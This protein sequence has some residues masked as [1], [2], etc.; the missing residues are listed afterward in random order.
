MIPKPK[1]SSAAE[2]II[3]FAIDHASWG[4]LVDQVADGFRQAILAGHYAPGDRLPPMRTIAKELGVSI[5][6]PTQALARLERERLVVGRP[7]IGCEVLDGRQPGWRGHLLIVSPGGDYG[8]SSGMLKSTVCGELLRSG[9]LVTTVPIPRNEHHQYDC[10]LLN[11]A[12]KQR[13]DV[14]LLLSFEAR[15]GRLIGKTGIPL[16]MQASPGHKLPQG[17]A[18]T[19]VHDCQDALNGFAAFCSGNGVRNVVVVDK[20]ADE[21]VALRKVLVEHGMNVSRWI[22]KPPLVTE[23]RIERLQKHSLEKFAEMLASAKRPDLFVFTDDYVA[24]ACIMCLVKNG[25]SIPDDVRVA[26]YA[27]AGSSLLFWEDVTR[28]E[29]DP[30]EQGRVLARSVLG[31]FDNK[32]MPGNINLVWRFIKGTTV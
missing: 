14:V 26:S 31:F 24:S 3:P 28:I 16:I 21:S 7:R 20:Y 1:K 4:S 5:R 25:M 8:F 12:L 32:S 17:I 22:L 11:H 29:F 30:V 19:Y 9:Y 6:I 10:T 15:L 27:N 2:G 23:R 18:G 13:V